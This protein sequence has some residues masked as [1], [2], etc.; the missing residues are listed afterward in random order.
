MS[1]TVDTKARD[2]M[3]L[4]SI[5]TRD[6][7]SRV[8]PARRP[9][10]VNRRSR[11]EK[12]M[13]VD[14]DSESPAGRMPRIALFRGLWTVWTVPLSQV[15]TLAKTVMTTDSPQAEFSMALFGRPI[16]SNACK[17][18]I[19]NP[20]TNDDAW[21]KNLASLEDQYGYI[22]SWGNSSEAAGHYPNGADGALTGR[23]V[24]TGGVEY[25]SQRP[26]WVWVALYSPVST[27]IGGRLL[28]GPVT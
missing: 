15:G 17:A 22:T 26:P 8:D 5:L 12:D 10:S 2:A 24:D 4:S 13:A 16:T 18:L 1:V 28:P 23:L 25:V 7:G 6:R 3:T 19:G 11:Q 14:F 27:F 21:T 20:L 9:G